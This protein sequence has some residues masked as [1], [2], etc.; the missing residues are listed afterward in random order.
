VQ[1][2]GAAA[3]SAANQ[4]NTANIAAGKFTEL[5]QDLKTGDIAT[6]VDK[7]V[8]QAGPA[9][10]IRTTGGAQALTRILNQGG[11]LSQDQQRILLEQRDVQRRLLA[12]TERGYIGWQV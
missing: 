1:A 6:R 5:I 2:A 3:A 11:Q 8:Q 10:D 7:A 4:P 9:Q 12:V